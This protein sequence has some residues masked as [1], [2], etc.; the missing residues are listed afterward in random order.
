MH[1]LVKFLVKELADTDDVTIVETENG[2]N[3]VNMDIFIDKAN[4]GKI[5]GRQGRIAKAIRTVI[6]A[7]AGKQGRRY[8]VAIKEKEGEAADA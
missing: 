3:A 5:I 6:K 1:D 4:I 7:A 2:E 8:N